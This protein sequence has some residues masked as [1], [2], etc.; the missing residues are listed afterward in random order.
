MYVYVFVNEDQD[1]DNK[2][3]DTSIITCDLSYIGDHLIREFLGDNEI[4]EQ[5]LKNI[6][7]FVEP[8]E[9]IMETLDI[10]HFKT[11]LDRILLT[12][13]YE[14]AMYIEK[15]KIVSRNEDREENEAYDINYDFHKKQFVIGN[16]SLYAIF[17]ENDKMIVP[18]NE[19]NDSETILHSPMLDKLNRLWN[20]IYPESLNT[21]SKR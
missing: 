4:L 9:D 20:I 3:I 15:C 16:D 10:Y 1:T 21:I 7:T 18:E 6:C 17:D 5:K 14:N 2:Y 19:I 13:D 12:P 11:C 8:N